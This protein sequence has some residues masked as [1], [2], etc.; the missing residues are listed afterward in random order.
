MS[1]DVIFVHLVATTKDSLDKCNTSLGISFQRG[2]NNVILI[3][4]YK[5][6]EINMIEIPYAV[7]RLFVRDTCLC[8][9]N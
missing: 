8:W 9:N 1:A 6:L 3:C 5:S 4:L 7:Y 2:N